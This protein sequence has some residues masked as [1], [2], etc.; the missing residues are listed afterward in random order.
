[1]NFYPSVTFPYIAIID[2]RTGEHMSTFTETDP[3]AFC[4][5][6]KNFISL[7]GR[8]PSNLQF[9]ADFASPEAGKRKTPDSDVTNG[10]DSSALAK[11]SVLCN[12]NLKINF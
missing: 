1:M 12:S 9:A 6:L 5:F 7:H 3:K 10:H 2:S 11:L 4:K 8:M